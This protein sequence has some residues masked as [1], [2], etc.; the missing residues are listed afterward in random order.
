[1]VTPKSKKKEPKPAEEKSKIAQKAQVGMGAADFEGERIE[2]KDID[3]VEVILVDFAIF[4][5][6]FR[7]EKEYVCL[8]LEVDGE[9]RVGFIGGEVVVNGLK[10]LNKEEDLPGPVTFFKKQSKDGTKTYWT[11]R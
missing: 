11:M 1:M 2:K 6:R 5:S 4:P 3:G 8:Q 7:E 9:L 10:N